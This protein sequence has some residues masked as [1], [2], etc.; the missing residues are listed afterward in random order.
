MFQHWQYKMSAATP[1]KTS[2]LLPLAC[3]LVVF[4]R[5]L[6]HKVIKLYLYYVIVFKPYI[7]SL[8]QLFWLK[9]VNFFFF[10]QTQY[11]LSLTSINHPR[12]R[13]DRGWIKNCVVLFV[14]I[15]F[16]HVKITAQDYYTRV[17]FS[18]TFRFII[19]SHI[20]FSLEA[21]AYPKLSKSNVYEN[22]IPTLSFNSTHT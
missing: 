9:F 17:C 14:D 6:T 21:L 20:N 4:C 2:R 19:K 18:E 12:N 7:L 16:Y 15:F 13:S 3:F 11:H 10:K 22:F 8:P 1:T 5:T